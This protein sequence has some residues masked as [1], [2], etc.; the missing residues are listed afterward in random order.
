MTD[1]SSAE[2]P[3]L[4]GEFPAFDESTWRQLVDK[5]LK[6][7]AADSLTR[8]TADEIRIRPL[9]TA[10][11]AS[12][13]AGMPGSAPF[14]R[15]ASASGSAGG[16]WDVRQFHHAVD[17]A[18]TNAAILEDLEGGASSIHLRLI[19]EQTPDIE[20][21][22]AGVLLDVAAVGLEAGAAFAPAATRL[23]EL[24]EQ[25]GVDRALLR[26][27]LNADPLG[28]AVA[29]AELEVASGI[30]AAAALALTTS[31]TWS[32]VTTL[33]ADGR[34]YHAGGA[35]E[36]QELAFAVATGIAYLRA[37]SSAGMPA[38]AAARQIGFAL[39]TD[40]DFFLTVAKL[41]ALRRLWGRVLEVVDA[42][43]AMPSLRLHAE[44]A[45]R[46]L[47]RLDPHVNILRGT[48]A[49]FA[50]AAGGASSITVLPFDHAIGPPSPL[51][52]RI[53][54]NTQLVL[55]EESCVGRVIDPAGGAWLVERLTEAIAERAWSLVQEVERR[56]GMLPAL[57]EGWPQQQVAVSR[58]RLEREV[59]C[60]RAPITG[61]SEFADLGAEAPPEQEARRT[62]AGAASVRPIPPYRL[63]L[64]FER[65]RALGAMTRASGGE[66][67]AVFLA[68][69]GVRAQF[70]GRETFARNLFEAGGFAAPACGELGS[71]EEVGRAF[72]ASGARQAAI[73]S[74]DSVYG[75]SAQ[76]AVHA[77]KDAGAAVIYL[78][79]RPSDAQRAAW[80][81]AGVDEFVFAGCDALSLL[82]RAHARETGGVA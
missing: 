41:R 14:V 73:C 46:M 28:A 35:S 19:P 11:D 24:A 59:A 31:S 64:G 63:A 10:A 49:A 74:S 18:A 57:V 13:D 15:G 44:T 33:L 67:P 60:R 45:T 76:A 54:R 39:T 55:L 69:L 20:Q 16:G 51:A 30:E 8:T 56:G 68:T 4:A 12:H 58:E 53:A 26:A 22:L 1:I 61:V 40:A 27:E 52:R 6:G 75:D 3:V 25:E 71:V 2:V 5:A 78:M 17:V 66:R 77:L 38:S 32:G 70:A 72:A 80:S 23:L 62:D 34:P 9:Y 47:T 21:L 43:A 81:A 50:A 79:G 29:G 36:A 42:Q 37:L 48:V 82:E 65:V 7:A